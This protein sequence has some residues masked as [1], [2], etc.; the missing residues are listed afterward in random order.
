MTA[1]EFRASQQR[2]PA[3][4]TT[5]PD[6]GRS[7]HRSKKPATPTNSLTKALLVLLTLEGCTVWRQNNA[8]VFDNTLQ[9]WRAGSSNPGISD[10]LGYHRATGRFLAIEVKVGKDKLRPEQITFLEEVRRAGG[11]ACEGRSLEQVRQ[12]FT[13]WRHS[14]GA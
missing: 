6:A 3:S 2:T 7:A 12:E 13:Q 1:A 8:G 11:F 4:G 14:L 5:T 9:V 10:I